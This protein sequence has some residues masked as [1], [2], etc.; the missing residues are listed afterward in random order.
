MI[1]HEAGKINKEADG[2]SR[3]YLLLFTLESKVSGFKCV[4]DMYTKDE[5]FKEILAKCSQH[6]YDLFHLENGFLSKG[7]RLCIPRSGF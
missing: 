6:A 3:R 5:D 7:T 4:K 1:H 2:L